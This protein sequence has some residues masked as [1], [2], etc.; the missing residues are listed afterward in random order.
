MRRLSELRFN[1]D[2][3]PEYFRWLATS[4][5]SGYKSTQPGCVC[6]DDPDNPAIGRATTAHDRRGRLVGLHHYHV[7][8]LVLDNLGHR[9]IDTGTL[10]SVCTWVAPSWRRAGV[11]QALWARSLTRTQPRRVS[12]YT[13]TKKSTEMCLKFK[14]KWRGI[15][16]DVYTDHPKW[17]DAANKK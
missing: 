3:G 13:I 10:Q 1:A 8:E 5:K 9:N 12:V 7:K 4:A 16:W 15:T 14:Q 11:A 6:H 17:L 2:A